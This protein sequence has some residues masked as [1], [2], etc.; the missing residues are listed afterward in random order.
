MRISIL[1]MILSGSTAAA[2]QV[3][4]NKCLERELLIASADI[5]PLLSNTNGKMSGNILEE[6]ELR[7]NKLNLNYEIRVYPWAR[8]LKL[9]EEG[10][11]DALT[12]TLFSVHQQ[13]F[14]DFTTNPVGS[15]NVSLFENKNYSSSNYQ[16]LSNQ[17]IIAVM[18][19]MEFD[20]SLLNGA[21]TVETNNFQTG[22]KLLEAQR[23]DLLLGVEEIINNNLSREKISDVVI[24]RRLEAHPVYLALAKNARNYS[25]LKQCLINI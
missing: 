14:L 13:V 6:L 25:I 15:V 11:V 18:R 23:V 17:N 12:P 24:Y 21:R 9:A 2:T 7:L 3:S 20:R 4:T 8:A 16:Q 19:S 10:K 22:I 5:P 1:A